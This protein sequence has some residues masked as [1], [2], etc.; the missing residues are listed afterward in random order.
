[1]LY[2]GPKVARFVLVSY[3]CGAVADLSPRFALFPSFNCPSE[4]DPNAPFGVFSIWKVI[5]VEGMLWGFGTAIGE[6]PPYF[7]SL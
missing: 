4:A 2:L 7:V 3:E 6:L 5:A 1:M